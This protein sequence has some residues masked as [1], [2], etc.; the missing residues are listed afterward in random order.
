[1]QFRAFGGFVC[2]RY[3][4]TFIY[5][6]PRKGKINYMI[7]LL[8]STYDGSSFFF[9]QVLAGQGESESR[10]RCR[11]MVRMLYVQRL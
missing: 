10:R 7:N 5:L 8:C 2:K 9:Y 11:R 3:S 1:M 4:D 6:F